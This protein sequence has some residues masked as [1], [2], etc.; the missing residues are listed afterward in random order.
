LVAKL[1]IVWQKTKNY[2]KNLADSEK[3]ITFAAV[4]KKKIER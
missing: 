4:R 2:K 3:R 1:R